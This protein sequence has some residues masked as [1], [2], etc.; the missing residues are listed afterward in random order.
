LGQD[1]EVAYVYDDAWKTWAAGAGKRSLLSTHHYEWPE[2]SFAPVGGGYRLY[3]RPLRELPPSLG[4]LPLEADLG[5]VRLLGY[6]IR[7]EAQPGEV[8]EVQLAWRAVGDQAPPPSFTVRLFTPEG[9]FVAQRDLFLGSETAEGEVRFANFS[10]FLPLD[11]CPGAVQPR[12]GVY[13]VIEGAF[14]NL[15]EIALPALPVACDLPVLPATRLHPGVVTGGGPFLK[16]VDYDVQRGGASVYLHWCGPGRALVV[17]AG[18]ETKFVDRLW[19]GDCR[20]VR[21]PLEERSGQPPVLQLSRPTGEAVKLLAPPLPVPAPSDT[22]VPFSNELVLVDARTV[23]R[24]GLLVV[25]LTWRSLQPLV[26]D[27]AVSV[28]L[29]AEGG[30]ELGIHDMQPAL[31][32]LP[33]LKWGVEGLEILDPHPF[34]MP[35][36]PPVWAEV[37]VYE[38]FRLNRLPAPGADPVTVFLPEA[39][40]V[41]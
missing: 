29:K 12:V 25:D 35:N 23:T 26:D 32:A 30:L 4:Y 31:S 17:S 14:E 10:L 40:K 21:L 18:G 24:G 27:Y 7:G 36:W 15:G 16:G 5:P 3:R 1:V 33:T 37:A 38:R 39:P 20:S 41:R 22:Y 6:R 19:P 28:R 2:W 34:S 8:L 9:A 11:S 13:T